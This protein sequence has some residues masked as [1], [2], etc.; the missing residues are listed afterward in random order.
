MFF[1]TAPGISTTPEIERL[2]AASSPVA[3]GISGGKDSSALAIATNEYLDSVGHAG[4][5][6]LIHSDLGV[7]EWRESLPWCR[8]L[9]DRLGME[10]IITRRAKG[11]MMDRWEQ[12]WSDNVARY[13]ALKCVKLILPWSTPG[14]R[15]CTSEMKVAPICR[16]LT[17][18]FEGQTIINATGIR[19]QESAG[20]ADAPTAKVQPKLMSKSKDTSGIDWHPIADW[21][22]EEV[23]AFLKARQFDLHPAYTQWLLTRVSCA[24]CIMSSIGDLRN[25]ARCPNN[26]GLYRRM[27]S[28][29]AASGF[30]FHGALW[31][32][33]VAPELLDASMLHAIAYA[34]SAAE[35]RR[36]AE[37]RIPKHLLYVKGWPHFIP[38]QEEAELLCEVRITVA[39]ACGLAI[40]YASP[41]SLIERYRQLMAEKK[42]A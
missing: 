37:S 14:M 33:D 5:R 27:V 13:A 10:L 30:A 42:A 15:F 29:E 6:V 9:A 7:T 34:K 18:R 20:R 41:E 25:A 2:I 17:H 16:E 19:R 1:R 4:P 40:E 21:S 11:D 8:K 26:H 28:L 32:A 12:R 39:I 23:F 38:T 22:L 31:L 36:K 35:V 3:M 24:F